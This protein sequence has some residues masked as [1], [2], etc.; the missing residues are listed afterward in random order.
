MHS[1]RRVSNPF[2]YILFFILFYLYVFL[3]VDPR[4]LYYRAPELFVLDAGFFKNF[5][6]YPG[7]ISDY[8]SKFFLEFYYFPWAGALVITLFTVFVCFAYNWFLRG[9]S[10]KYFGILFFIPAAAILFTY[11]RYSPVSVTGLSLALICAVIYIRLSRKSG[12]ASLFLYLALSAFA[13]YSAVN[14]YWLFASL[15]GVWEIIK[16]KRH[17]L[18]WLYLGVEVLIYYTNA[19]YVL[20]IKSA[21]LAYYLFPL[22]GSVNLPVGLLLLLFLSLS[23]IFLVRVK[24]KEGV[25]AFLLAA[26]VFCQFWAEQFFS[27]ALYIFF[28]FTPV[29]LLYF[30]RASGLT[31]RFS[32]V[33]RHKVFYPGLVFLLAL[34]LLMNFNKDENTFLKI[35]YFSQKKM[36]GRVLRESRGISYRIYQK[37]K[38][39]Y[40]IA[41]KALYYTGRLPYEEFSYPSHLLFN[42]P[43][44][45]ADSRLTNQLEPMEIADTCFSLGLINHS[46]LMSFWALERANEPVRAMQQLVYIYILRGNDQAAEVLLNRFKK[47]LLYRGWARRY[48]RILEDRA[49]LKKNRYLADAKSRM[50]K[51]DARQDDDTLIRI[52]YKYDYEAVFKKLLAQNPDNRMAFEYLMSYYMLMGQ[53]EKVIENIGRLDNF[54]YIG[55]PYTYQEAVLINIFKTTDT[56]PNLQGRA[57]DPFVAQKYYYFNDMYRKYGH[58]KV[59]TYDALRKAGYSRNYFLYYIMLTSGKKK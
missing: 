22:F 16:N 54:G 45:F 28:L 34:A 4:L 48:E 24:S 42:M 46:E 37:N 15:C 38:A 10:D 5:L 33:K 6:L 26:L 32:A 20:Y 30:D 31:A 13:Y 2:G 57:L 35:N 53:T 7:G 56:N 41:F 51:K 50:I 36:W 52:A 17:A 59:A 23:I 3:R 43:Y 25:S 14:F 47:S 8:L 40:E 18:G 1:T 21:G 9:L 19:K 44:P 11:N 27:K 58:D 49:L 55:M 12:L 29:I 39:L